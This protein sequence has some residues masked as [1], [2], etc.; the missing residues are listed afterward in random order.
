MKGIVL[1]AQEPL[2]FVV[3]MLVKLPKFKRDLWK[4]SAYWLLL[5]HCIVD[6]CGKQTQQ[7]LLSWNKKVDKKDFH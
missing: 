7:A 3:K 1:I 6:S 2:K 4:T 5:F